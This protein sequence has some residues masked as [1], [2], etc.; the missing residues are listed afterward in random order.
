M[1]KE[2]LSMQMVITLDFLNQGGNGKYKA[3]K[4]C[5]FLIV[6]TII[7]LHCAWASGKGSKYVKW[8]DGQITRNKYEFL[9]ENLKELAKYSGPFTSLYGR[10]LDPK[11]KNKNSIP[12]KGALSKVQINYS[13]FWQNL[14]HQYVFHHSVP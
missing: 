3:W 6:L 1:H 8:P 5:F 11:G 12:C 4:V 14:V 9:E 13:H 7:P 10:V 2:T